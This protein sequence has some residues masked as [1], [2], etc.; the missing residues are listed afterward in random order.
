MLPTFVI[1]LREGLEAA[2]IVG[3]VAAFLGRQRREALRWMWLGVGV[4]VALS[5]AV[6]IALHVVSEQ[7]PQR[8]QEGL[9]TV[10]ALV[11]VVVVTYMIVWMK[12]HSREL[13]GSLEQQALVALAQ[14]SA[15]A[16][17]AMA[18]FAVIR[19]GFETA[20]FLLA[21]FDATTNAAA[22]GAGAALGV[23]V[24][25][26]LGYGIYRGGVRINLSRFFRLTGIALVVVAAGLVSSA[27]HTAH[28]A[29]WLNSFQEQ[30]LDLSWLVQPGTVRSALLTGMLG[31][32]PKPTVA[33]TAG[34]L[35]YLVPL[36]LFVLWPR[37]PRPLARVP[38]G[39]AAVCAVLLLLVVGCG[40][41]GRG[42]PGDTTSSKG[43]AVTITDE[44]CPASL[45]L[46]AG[47]TTIAVTND[48]GG[49]VSEFEILDGNRIVGEVENI[50]PGLSGK[51]SLTLHP[52]SYVTYCPGGSRTEHGKLA[53]VGGE[54]AQATEAEQQAVTRYRRYVERQTDTLVRSTSAFVAALRAGSLARAK[55]LYAAARSPYE[56]IEPVAESFGNLDPAIDARA[57]DV[58][59]K[60]WT[61]FHAIERILWVQGT[62]R[63]TGALATKLLR[64]VHTL[65]TRVKTVE[66]E[67]AQ[68]ANGSVELLNEVS[69]SKITG[70]EERYSRIDLLDFAANVDGSRAA[71]DSV[72][73]LLGRS[74]AALASQIV[75][76]FG[77]VDEA[78]SRYR[79]GS[80][81]VPYDDL[82]ASDTRTLS[83]G[84]DALAEPLSRVG[85][86]VVG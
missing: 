86:I 25:V 82:T 81:Y 31:I 56:R 64:D 9:E 34:Y 50:A 76:R 19:E 45:R 75:T 39:L 70:E 43:V 35:I 47:P 29:G 59:A 51:F 65:E 49:S 16:L 22:A 62:T 48:G 2:L 73:P 58:P 40:S 30:A 21:A 85:A 24:A 72:R 6:G 77:A 71:F 28:E 60:S 63:G 11:A 32:Q 67:P 3:I 57:G 36:L 42:I 68:I 37:Q 1:G 69:K 54:Q 52:G 44:G 46:P 55:E 61:G 27:A 78:L 83:Q 33:E 41:D 18:F 13:K 66:L 4:A 23:A 38:A 7:L 17:V 5:A 26:V 15:V 80:G 74:H 53:V 14:G 12:R 10:V 79:R 84:I 20:V 8:E